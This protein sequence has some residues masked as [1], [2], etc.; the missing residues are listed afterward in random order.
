MTVIYDVPDLFIDH[1]LEKKWE[2]V[3]EHFEVAY[4]VK[5]KSKLSK[6]QVEYLYREMQKLSVTSREIQK[7]S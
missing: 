4:H 3:K 7:S 5:F 6:E 2:M 1:A